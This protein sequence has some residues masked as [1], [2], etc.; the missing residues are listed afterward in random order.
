LIALSGDDSA[1]NYPLSCSVKFDSVLIKP[2]SKQALLACIGDNAEQATSS[3]GPPTRHPETGLGAAVTGEWH[4]EGLHLQTIFCTELNRQLPEL[5]AQITALDWKRAGGTLHRLTGAAAIAGFT[6]FALQGRMLLIQIHREKNLARLA[7][8]YL[9]FLIQ[10]AR[11]TE[12]QP[13]MEMH[14]LMH[15]Q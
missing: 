11:L 13:L 4:T 6:D 2:V 8:L 5:D 9:D 3:S 12:N 7:E 1:R 10:A 14:S 15:G